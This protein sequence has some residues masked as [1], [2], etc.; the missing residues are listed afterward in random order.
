MTNAEFISDI[1]FIVVIYKRKIS[2][3]ESIQS[4]SMALGSFTSDIFIYDNSPEFNPEIPAG[5]AQCKF[6]YMHDYNNSGV[7]KAY[8]SGSALAGQMNKRWLLLCDQDT[9]FHIEYL[10]ELYAILHLFNPPLVAPYLYSNSTLISPC[11]FNLNYAYPLNKKLQPGF[12]KLNGISLL[13]SGICISQEAYKNCGGYDEK[14]FLDF[15]DFDFM[16]RFKKTYGKVYLLNVCLTHDLESAFQRD[17][18]VQRFIRY[19]KSYR[20]A[21]HSFCD[22]ITLSI[23]SGLRAVKQSFL[24]RSFLPFKLFL[25]FFITNKSLDRNE[26]TV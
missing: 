15:S 23:I 3:C 5:I 16:K 2:E 14:V 7:S 10:N 19:N 13:N 4:L 12:H 25:L 21:V 6:H 9:L 18:N 1:L 22:L 17:F 20:G 8:N 26:D 24:Y 11:G